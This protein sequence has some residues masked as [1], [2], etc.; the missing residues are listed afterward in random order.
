M[1]AAAPAALAATALVAGLGCR[2]PHP[3]PV[4]A[5]PSEGISIAV[6][7][8]KGRSYAVV[9]DR[10]TVEVTG[11]TIL[12][13][14]IEPGAALATLLIEPL[15]PAG[16]ALAIDQCARERLAV[17][18]GPAAAPRPGSAAR[19]PAVPV[20]ASV[21]S[22]LVACAVTGRPG[23]YLVRVH[24]VAASIGF[25]TQ[26]E[27]AMTAPDRATVST[28][29]VVSAP[30]WG[31]RAEVVLHDGAPGAGEPPRVLA[32]G[33]ITLDGGAA[34]IALPPRDVPARLVHV[35]DGMTR[36]S[37]AD[38]TD[39]AWGRESHRDVRAMLEL[40]DAQLLPAPAYVRIAAGDDVHELRTAYAPDAPSP[41]EDAAPPASLARSAPPAAPRRLALWIESVAPRQPQA[42]RPPRRRRHVR[43]SLR[44]LGHEPRPRAA[45]ALDRGAAPPRA[46]PRDPARAPVPAGARRRHRAHQARRRP[47]QDRAPLVHD[48]LLVLSAA[49]TPVFRRAPAPAPA[50]RA[51]RLRLA[52]CPVPARM[53]QC[54]E[55]RPAPPAHGPRGGR[56][57]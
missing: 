53:V 32:R 43:Q 46:P 4:A 49:A 2:P 47:G 50:P 31:G 17:G 12:L 11:R 33:T 25:R 51:R 24:H 16:A 44:A 35:Y 8:G 19:S 6:Y 10:R 29:F 7:A 45:R 39:A 21:P 15:G 37:I 23:R 5:V 9:D 13:D 42:H 1:P 26:H 3:A 28:R 34:V 52:S 22:P 38:R 14:R 27:I 18:P 20:P 36:G 54:S 55:R 56:T 48:P 41:A 40:D 57:A 30:A